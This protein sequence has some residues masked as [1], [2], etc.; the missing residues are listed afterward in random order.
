[1]SPAA[2]GRAHGCCRV[3]ADMG[4]VDRAARVFS[5]SVSAAGESRSCI[6]R[7][8]RAQVTGKTY[9]L[10]AG[11]SSPEISPLESAAEREGSRQTPPNS[12]QSCGMKEDLGNCSGV[13]SPN[14]TLAE[15]FSPHTCSKS[16]KSA[17]AASSITQHNVKNPNPEQG[18]HQHQQLVVT[19]QQEAPR[20]RCS[21]HP[22]PLLRPQPGLLARLCL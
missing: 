20:E 11:T 14:S 5:R 21:A 12:V 9:G 2:A 22:A 3:A 17:A 13:K 19:L 16:R 6:K 4:F 15:L 7:K 10:C 18:G 1:M 8:R